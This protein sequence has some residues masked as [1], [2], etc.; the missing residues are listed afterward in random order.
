MASHRPVNCNRNG[1]HDTPQVA[2]KMPKACSFLI[3][4]W[5]EWVSSVS[6]CGGQAFARA[7]SHS[8]LAPRACCIAEDVVSA[9]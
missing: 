9:R 8:I 1:L 4:S 3:Q 6:L 2:T 7:R 5:V